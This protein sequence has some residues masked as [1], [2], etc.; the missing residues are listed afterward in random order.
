VFTDA[1]VYVLLADEKEMY[2]RVRQDE[3]LVRFPRSKTP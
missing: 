1:G 2:L 3:L